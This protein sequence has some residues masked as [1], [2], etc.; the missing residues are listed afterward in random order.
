MAIRHE[1]NWSLEMP[2]CEVPPY[3]DSVIFTLEAALGGAPLVV[4]EVDESAEGDVDEAINDG[5]DGL[6]ALGA[7]GQRV[8]PEELK[9]ELQR[10]HQSRQQRRIAEG[11]EIFDVV[12]V[13]VGH[14]VQHPK[15]SLDASQPTIRFD[16]IGASRG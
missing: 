6:L 15:T 2:Y 8:T 4:G 9:A 16:S 7:G 10:R 11:N 1:N 3:L 13:L 5:A 14:A 12:L